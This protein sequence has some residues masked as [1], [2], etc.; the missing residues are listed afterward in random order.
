MIKNKISGRLLKVFAAAAIIILFVIFAKENAYAAS[1]SH[2][3]TDSCYKNATKTCTHR[4]EGEIKYPT[5]HCNTCGTMQTFVEIVHWEVCPRAGRINVA[6]TEYCTVCNTYRKTE[7][8]SPGS[9]TYTTKSLACGMDENTPVAEV[10][11]SAASTA[12]TNGSVT[13]NVNVSGG[14]AE[15]ALAEAPYDFG[16]GYTSNSSFDVTEN[17]TYNATVMDARGRTV[18]VSCAVDCIDKDLPVIDSVTKSTEAWTEDGVTLTVAAHDDKSGL[19]A[20]AYS[21]NGGAFSSS[22]SAKITANGDISIKVRDAAGNVSETV[23]HVGNIGRDPAVVEAERKEAERKEAERKAAEKEAAEKAEAEKEAAE[24]EASEKAAKDSK[25]PKDSGKNAIDKNSKT[26]DKTSKTSTDKKVKIDEKA[27]KNAV[28]KTVKAIVASS[29][30]QDAEGKLITVKDIT[31]ASLK[32]LEA[33]DVIESVNDLKDTADSQSTMDSQDNDASLGGVS[34]LKASV[35]G[36]AVTAGGILLLL[37]AFVISHFNYVYILQGGKKRIICRCRVITD[38]D[39]L[40]AVVP[41]AKLKGHGKYL[42]FISPWKKD[43][44]KKASVSVKLEGEDHL[45]PTDEGVAFK[46]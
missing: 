34:V 27:V 23:I 12:P 32:E 21:I 26:G 33:G 9:H 2:V 14:S 38:G 13:L 3:H 30:M 7:D 15:F 37:G 20:E 22:D 8:V 29:Q 16:Q 11:M 6:Y 1:F 4:V 43:F 31:K 42:L 36:V 44:K 24:K 40:T 18:T 41:K 46:Y 10:S 17:G 45:I 35:G 25:N 28:K 19:H 39:K 5:F